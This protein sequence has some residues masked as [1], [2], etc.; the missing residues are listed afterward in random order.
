MLCISCCNKNYNDVKNKNTN[1][2][3]YIHYLQ[4]PRYG[5]RLNV[6]AQMNG[7]RRGGVCLQWNTT[8]A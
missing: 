7:E 6:H 4:L 2:K 3:R 5:N 1:L 8:Q